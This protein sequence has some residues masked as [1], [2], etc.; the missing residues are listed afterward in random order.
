M[1]KIK[2]LSRSEYARRFTEILI[3]ATLY[4]G[5]ARL[6]LLMAFAHKNVSPVW[7]PTGIALA[8]LL[9]FG[10]RFWPGVALGA[11]L[12]NFSTGLPFG[13]ACAIGAGNTFEA[14]LGAH[15]LRRIAGFRNSLDRLQDVLG[16]I[17]LAVVLSTTVAATI[18]VVSLGLSG[19]IRWAEFGS[20]WWTWWLGDAMGALVVAP[21]LLTW[22]AYCDGASRRRGDGARRRA[23]LFRPASLS[24]RLPVSLEAGVLIVSLVTASSFA[25]KDRET[26]PYVIFPFMI[27]TVLRFGQPGTAA[28]N[29]VV[30]GIAIWNTVRGFGPFATGSA[31]QS[32]LALQTY[33]GMVSA[34]ALLLAAAVTERKRTEEELRESEEAERRFSE[35][36]LALH[37]VSNQLSKADSLADL[38]RSAVELGRSRLGFDRLGIWFADEDHTAATGSFGVDETGQL[39]DERGSRVTISPG[40]VAGEVLSSKRLFA[41]RVDAPVMDNRAD[42]VGR[43]AHAIAGLWNGEE[44]IGFVSTDNLLLRQPI[45]ER[46]CKLLTLYAS[47]LG[48]LCSLKR[49]EEALQAREERFR[50]VIE[51]SWDGVVLI[52]PDG[53]L[54]YGTTAATRIVGYKV[55]DLPGRNV[56]ELV[57]PDD[58]ERISTLFA[59]LL[60]TPGASVSAQFRFAHKDG[61]WLWLEATAT[62]LLAE[63]AVQAVVANFVDITERKQAEEALRQSEERFRQVSESGMLS[64]AF[65][66]LSGQI[67]DANDAFLKMIGYNREEL[68][69]GMVHWKRLTPPEWTRRSAQ[70]AQELKTRGTCKPYE[71]ECFRRNGTRFWVLLGG[72][73]L[74]GR[75]EGVAFVVDITNRKHAEEVRMALLRRLSTAQE[76]ERHRIARE[77]HDQMGQHLTALMLGLK[78]LDVTP[79]RMPLHEHLQQLQDLSDEIGREVHRIALELRPTALDDFGLHAA[80]LNYVA[81]WSDRSEIEVDF[82]SSGLDK[83]RLP[84]QLET[85]LY[86]I[87]QEALT[88]VIKHAHAKRVS[89]LLEHRRDHVLAIVEDDG[90]GF[91]TEAV[92]DA[93]SAE[94]RLG[95]LGMR[96]RVALVG[97]TLEIETSPGSGTT[98][99]VRIPLLAEG[100]VVTHD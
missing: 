5:A 80:L 36:L 16:L 93:A 3:C 34:T 27:W 77:L 60:Q 32:L 92:M 61:P 76:E 26:L 88:N 23:Q 53:T 91:D 58:R 15:L 46:Q 43:G 50:A 31:E 44:A 95:L 90:E 56:L 30:S 49:A 12:A 65:F 69:T 14:L 7:P 10:S 13:T 2:G 39:R 40:S 96:E 84:P 66:D 57:H 9:I 98:V 4:F 35:Q 68:R 51:K 64:I 73:L 86:R 94:P 81:E 20:A 87:V 1:D 89:I 70:A 33:R 11:F 75:S 41:L 28:A 59:R 47:A 22:S 24:P 78:S 38:C 67:T 42:R 29:L 62:N 54:T 21:A 55:A 71:K 37:E 82:H 19:I 8:A 79:E 97:G 17:T 85:T 18:G 45:T 48:H 63:P 99:F 72:A 25:F 83:Q 52:A 6:G 100:Q 74:E